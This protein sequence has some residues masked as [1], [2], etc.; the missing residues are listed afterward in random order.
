MDNK[1]VTGEFIHLKTS[2]LPPC[3]RFGH[4]MA[5]LPV[6]N[7]IVVT[8]GRNDD[9]CKKQ[10]TPFLSDLHLFLLDQKVWIKVKYSCDSDSLD[11]ICNSSLSI[12][13]DGDKFER[14][15][16]F[17]GLKNTIKTT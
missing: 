13:T 1:V 4:S 9:L 17:G 11:N 15:I 14:I 6:S 16:L 5:F 7:A 10:I 8:G 2:G 12:V 3:P